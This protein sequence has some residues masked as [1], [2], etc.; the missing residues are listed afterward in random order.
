MRMAYLEKTPRKDGFVIRIKQCGLNTSIQTKTKIR[1]DAKKLLHKINGRIEQ[2]ERNELVFPGEHGL[3]PKEIKRQRLQILRYGKLLD[4]PQEQHGIAFR[5]AVDQYLE[6]KKGK[7]AYNTLKGYELNLKAA[8]EHFGDARVV[9]LTKLGIQEFVRQMES[10]S[11]AVKT[12][13]ARAKQIH[14]MLG[15]LESFE[16]IPQGKAKIATGLDFQTEPD[17]QNWEEWESLSQ[18][19]ATLTRL[20][21]PL[22]NRDYFSKVFLDENE[23]CRFVAFARD[24]FWNKGSFAQRRLFAALF[25]ATHTGVRRSEIARVHRNDVDLTSSEPSVRV[26]LRKGRGNYELKFHNVPLHDHLADLLAEWVDELPPSKCLLFTPT[27]S[28]LVNG[29]IDQIKERTAADNLGM[30]LTRNLAG[31]EFQFTSGWHIHRHSLLTL[32]GSMGHDLDTAMALVN[33]RTRKVAEM[34]RHGSGSQSRDVLNQ[35]KISGLGVDRGVKNLGLQA[36][37]NPART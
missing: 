11:L 32:I 31:T 5:E 4:T 35:V 29:K 15:W 24:K 30:Q 23:L 22:D 28:I 13:K 33:H 14:T 8:K 26:G 25:F 9:T 1:R 12:I 6:A 20:G 16:L 19:I 36:Q 37:K 17:T 18:K 3:D 27:D 2:I 7:L 10:M 34:Y 21:L